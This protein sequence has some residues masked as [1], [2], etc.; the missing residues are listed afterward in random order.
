MPKEQKENE[1]VFQRNP[2][3]PS[4]TGRD[5][6]GPRPRR[7]F[8]WDH[9]PNDSVGQLVKQVVGSGCGLVLGATSDGGALSITILDGDKRV[10]EWPSTIDDY[11]LLLDW[12]KTAL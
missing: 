11:D 6:S 2:K 4:G 1:P 10:R 12:C 7:A 8:N 3:G 5:L 9:I